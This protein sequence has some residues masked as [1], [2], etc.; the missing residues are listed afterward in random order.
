MEPEEFQRLIEKRPVLIRMND[1]REFFIEKNQ[2]VMVGDNTAG[3]L[4]IDKGLKR[5]AVVTLGKIASVI[6]RLT[7]PWSA[8]R[9]Y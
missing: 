5:N 1:G 7:P 2:N 6:P 8:N 4:V 9:D 3:C